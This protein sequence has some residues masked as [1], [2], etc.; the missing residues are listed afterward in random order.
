VS[1]AEIGHVVASEG[2]APGTL[3]TALANSAGLRELARSP[4]WLWLMSEVY[5]SPGIAAA[6]PVQ[7]SNDARASLCDRYVQLKLEDSQAGRKYPPV[8]TRIWLAWLARNMGGKDR[9]FFFQ[10]MQP[11]LLSV[12]ADKWLYTFCF[13]ALFGLLLALL[14][15]ASREE[16]LVL[17]GLIGWF[18][19]WRD[20]QPLEHLHWRRIWLDF[21]LRLEPVVDFL[22]SA[23]GFFKGTHQ[24]EREV[25]SP[26]MPFFAKAKTWWKEVTPA[27]LPL[28]RT[29][30]NIAFVIAVLSFVGMAWH[31]SRQDGLAPGLASAFKNALLVF[32]GILLVM[33]PLLILAVILGVPL[34]LLTTG[35]AVAAFV[36]P[37]WLV[38]KLSGPIDPT[39][40][41]TGRE[42]TR[43][44]IVN[45]L[46][47]TLLG[48]SSTVACIGIV[49]G[50][51]R[52]LN[53][54]QQKAANPYPTWMA[55]FLRFAYAGAVF[56]LAAG[57]T[58]AIRYIVLRLILWMRG[59]IAFSYGRFL[60]YAT[61][62]ALLKR[63]GRGVIFTHEYLQGYFAS[64]PPRQRSQ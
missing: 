25:G 2:G 6:G 8:K 10:T 19:S 61:E 37:F 29:L 41:M 44:Q 56:G 34:F 28:L 62:R 49:I 24:G 60:K 21:Q 14:S 53:A 5:G 58:P 46:V 57:L 55:D 54:F 52:V 45:M 33:P 30:L 32:L 4:L 17:G 13:S 27:I 16:W 23:A 59:N 1:D 38:A 20:I 47:C 63:E 7:L 35:M 12:R 51:V 48:G 9:P 26:K 15:P 36:G 43:R 64:F 11:T 42:S 40:A 50:V 22:E 3:G 31:D 18:L 39:K